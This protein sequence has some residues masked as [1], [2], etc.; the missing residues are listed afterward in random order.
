MSECRNASFNDQLDDLLS[1]ARAEAAQARAVIAVWLEKIDA[2]TLVSDAGQVLKSHAEFSCAE[3]D[4]AYHAT[5]RV[6][7]ARECLDHPGCVEFTAC[8]LLLVH[9]G[10]PIIRCDW[11]S[12]PVEHRGEKPTAKSRFRANY[13]PARHKRRIVPADEYSVLRHFMALSGIDSFSEATGVFIGIAMDYHARVRALWRVKKHFTVNYGAA[14]RRVTSDG[15]MIQTAGVSLKKIRRDK[16]SGQ[17]M[18][19]ISLRHSGGKKEFTVEVPFPLP[20]GDSLNLEPALPEAPPELEGAESN[21]RIVAD[22]LG[23]RS[24]QVAARL[25]DA[26]TRWWRT[27]FGKSC[28]F[29]LRYGRMKALHWSRDRGAFAYKNGIWIESFD[30]DALSVTLVLERTAGRFK[31]LTIPVA[32]LIS[33]SLADVSAMEP[34]G[35]RIFVLRGSDG[36]NRGYA[37]RPAHGGQWGIGKTV[38]EASSAAG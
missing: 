27:H 4:D 21:L 29:G 38:L 6:I 9:R 20:R 33:E 1:R 22:F 30:S 16:A 34:D 24:D 10:Y 3:R 2:T 18:L 31:R 12:M 15:R 19:V 7:R 5:R 35:G 28:E 32:R 8:D 37:V 26:T 17:R 23:Q 25:T 13:Q 14:S 36:G 11:R